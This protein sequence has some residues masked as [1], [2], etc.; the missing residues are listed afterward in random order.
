MKLTDL[1]DGQW[2]QTILFDLDGTLVDSASDLAAAVDQML[3]ELGRPQ[4]GE[5]RVRQWIGNGVAVLVQR[6]LAGRHDHEAAG[7][8]DDDTLRRALDTFFNAYHEHNG[9]H[10]TVYDGIEGFLAQ[11]REQGC[12]LGVVT[13]KPAAFTDTL[14]DQ[15]GLSHWFDVTVSGDT[16]AV[17]KPHPDPLHHALSALDGEV[18]SALMVGDSVTDI[19]AARNAGLPVVAVRYGYNYGDPID[20][21]GAEIVVDSLAELL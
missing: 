20:S 1:F 11:A 12:R 14:L 6:A 19:H 18:G 16:L 21:L 8:L 2:P 13:N 10:A 15:M 9:L 4:A 7:P 5:G 17:K 3:T